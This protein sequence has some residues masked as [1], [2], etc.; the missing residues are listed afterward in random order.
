MIQRHGGRRGR[1]IVGVC[2]PSW[3]GRFG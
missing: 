2:L 1:G 3:S